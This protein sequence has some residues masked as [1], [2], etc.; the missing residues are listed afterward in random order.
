MDEDAKM[1]NKEGY[2]RAKKEAKLAVTTAKTAV[3]GL[4][5]EELGTKGGDKKLYRLAKVRERKTRDLDQVKCIKNEEGRVLMEEDH[6]R[7]RWQTY[8]PKFLN[9]EGDRDIMLGNLEHSEMHQ[10]FGYCRRIRVEEVRG[11]MRKM[12]RGR[13]T[14]PDEIPVKFWKNNQ[15]GFMSGRSAMEAIYI[16]RRLVEQYREMKK[17]LHMVF[18]SL[19]KAYDKVPREVLWRCLE[20][21]GVPVAYI[22]VIM[23][24]YDEAKTRVWAAGGDSE[25]FLAMTRLH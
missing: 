20:A 5:Y 16:V 10:D 12:H 8:L 17:D 6:I 22:K 4:L 15:F 9:E 2:R 21:K 24:M 25:H 18:I 13:V 1:M 7:R 11:P 14:R 3:F 19:E 23:D